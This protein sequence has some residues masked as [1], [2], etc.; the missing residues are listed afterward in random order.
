MDRANYLF[1]PLY[2]CRSEAIK[3]VGSPESG[4]S[5]PAPTEPPAA[6][7]DETF[8]LAVAK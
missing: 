7:T 5:L 1:V 4:A 8:E 6:Q 2:F 3:S